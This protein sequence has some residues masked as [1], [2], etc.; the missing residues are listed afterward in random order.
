MLRVD[1]VQRVRA[2]SLKYGGST[3]KLQADADAYRR[4]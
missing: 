3:G 1:V 2:S 4:S